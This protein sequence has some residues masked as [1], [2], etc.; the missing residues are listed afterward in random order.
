MTAAKKAAAAKADAKQI[1]DAVAVGKETVE[2]AVAATKEQVEKASDVA[3][4][5]YDELAALNK[6]NMDAFVKAANIMSK[7]VEDMGKA[8]W[9]F[10]QSSVET[11]VE[12]SKAMMGARTINDVVEI[13]TDLMRNSVDNAL[14]EG[15]KLTEMAVKVTNDS[16]AP[17]QQRYAATVEKAAKPVTF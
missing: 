11:G 14:A 17:L 6:D 9:A 16:V 8:Y 5:G 1:D 13:Q 10:A 3:L 15:T 4:R 2:K 12:A 7:G